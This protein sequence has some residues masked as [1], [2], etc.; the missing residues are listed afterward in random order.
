L[1]YPGQAPG[2]PPAEAGYA[3][4]TRGLVKHYGS[5]VALSGLDLAVPRGVVYGFLGP[6]GAGK[7][8]LMRLL[9][10]LIRPDAGEMEVL[11]QAYDWRRRSVLH[12]VGALVE[13]PVFYDY[14]SGRDNLRTLAASGARVPDG[15]VDEVLA[16]VGLAE[17]GRDK[18]GR[19]SLGM[20]QRLGI[21]AAL[22]SDPQLLL[23]DEPANGLDPGGIVAMRET[24]RYLTRQGKTV[25]VSS[26]ILPEVQQLADVVGIVD[27]GRLIREGSLSDLLSEGGHVSVQVAEA[28][29]PAAM[30]ALTVLAVP[31]AARP[32]GAP[33]VAIVDVRIQP[34]RAAEVNRALAAVGIYASGISSGSDLESVFLSLTATAPAPASAPATGWGERG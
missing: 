9:V 1:T 34:A 32:G 6:N 13:A 19:Y 26:H 15:R 5:Q 30:S 12:D 22:L 31:T 7:T 23:L 2:A 16:L 18:A 28:E 21:A 29:L 4:R 11:G 3:L 20:K 27:H 10:G 24:L 33:G 8:T 17:R 14:L 25:F